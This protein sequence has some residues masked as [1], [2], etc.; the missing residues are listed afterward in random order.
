M[1]RNVDV[2]GSFINASI[3]TAAAIT[4]RQNMNP[5]FQFDVGTSSD[6]DINNLTIYVN[7]ARLS[8]GQISGLESSGNFENKKCASNCFALIGSAVFGEPSYS[9]PALVTETIVRGLEQAC[10]LRSSI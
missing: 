8:S 6:S 10:S 4:N 1:S 5:I 2:N 9:L 3:F 7:G